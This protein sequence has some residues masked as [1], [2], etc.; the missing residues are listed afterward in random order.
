MLSIQFL[1]D[2]GQVVWCD[3]QVTRDSEVL[4]EV[5]NGGDSQKR[6]AADSMPRNHVR[7]LNLFISG[8]LLRRACDLVAK[9]LQSVFFLDL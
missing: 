2:A 6:V 3:K 5:Q 8:L 9:P 7:Q 4:E 1:Q